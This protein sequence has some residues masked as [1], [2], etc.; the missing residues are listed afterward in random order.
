MKWLANFGSRGKDEIRRKEVLKS[1]F[2]IC[3]RKNIRQVLCSPDEKITIGFFY[4]R[5]QILYSLF[6]MVF[7]IKIPKKKN[8]YMIHD[9]RTEEMGQDHDCKYYVQ[10]SK[11]LM[12]NGYQDL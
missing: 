10:I 8:R 9:S 5:L 7:S 3:W 4:S 6:F 12:Y 1:T 11:D 2:H